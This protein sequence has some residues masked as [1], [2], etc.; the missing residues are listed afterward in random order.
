M[1]T[2]SDHSRSAGSGFTL[3]EIL[4][5]VG[6]LGILVTVLYGTLSAGLN[7]WRRGSEATESF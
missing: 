4:L 5:A 2:S 1:N 3:L 7:S 6:I